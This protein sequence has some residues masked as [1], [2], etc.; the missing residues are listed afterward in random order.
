VSPALEPISFPLFRGRQNWGSISFFFRSQ[1]SIGIWSWSRRPFVRLV[2][3][4]T[5]CTFGG[6]YFFL[7]RTLQHLDP[8]R[9]VPDRVRSALNSLAEGLI[10]L[11][12]NERIVLVNDSFA[13][14]FKQAEGKLLGKPASQ[15]GWL[16]VADVPLA[17]LP[18]AETLKDGGERNDVA[19]SLQ[20]PGEE[21]R[22]FRVNSTPV[23]DSQGKR[24][25]VLATFNDITAIEKSRAALRRMLEELSLSRDEIKRQNHELQILA[26]RDPLTACLNRRSFFEQFDLQWQASTRSRLPL[27]C[28]MLDVDHFKQINDRHGHGAGDDVLRQVAATLRETIREVDYACRY[29]GEEFAVLLPQTT[30]D[31]ATTIAEAI[32]VAVN[33]CRFPGFTVSA[34]FGVAE[35]CPQT[36]DPQSLLNSADKCLYAAKRGGRNRVVRHDQLPEDAGT[37]E[38]ASDKDQAAVAIPF[39]SVNA[40]L[41]TLAYR[42]HDTAEHSRRVAEL[43]VLVASGL[44]PAKDVYLLEIA[45]LLHDIGKIGVPDAILLK[46]GPL[47]PE[48]WQVMSQQGRIGV[49][50]IHSAFACDPLTGI[51][52]DHHSWFN[53]AGDHRDSSGGFECQP[54]ARILQIADAY[55]SMVT[56]RSYRTARSQAEAFDELR[57]CSGTQFD[58]KLV[59]RFIGK[60]AA[61]EKLEQPRMDSADQ[62]LAMRI[63]REIERL[64]ETLDNQDLNG[65]EALASRLKNTAA[66][67]GV[68]AIA[69]VAEKLEE[70]ARRDNN[71]EEVFVLTRELLT[72]CRETQQAFLGETVASPEV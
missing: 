57:R 18:W 54:G 60:V 50:I 52:R 10:I 5:A 19:L 56:H 70:S 30:L 21:I 42:D 66:Q 64:A 71:L 61:R 45:A 69:Q 27:A 1:R 68:P 23:F 28:I 9:A 37:A 72:L 8:T 65:L 33:A 59:E 41:S 15:L 16:P 2:L 7:R 63:G 32:R 55:D 46:Q 11:D 35:R 25:G 26:T 40:L 43:V 48:E 22:H 34:S 36:L 53:S 24:R 31:Q 47:T 3:F 58:P 67:H 6:F 12:E 14:T 44:I 13:Q 62:R 17:A 49:E 4:V 39:H 51:V 20:T 29:G 38:T